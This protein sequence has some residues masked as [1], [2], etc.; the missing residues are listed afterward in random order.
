MKRNVGKIDRSLRIL[1]GFGIMLAGFYYESWLG[2]F[3]AIPLATGTLGWCPLY[4]PFGF[5]SCRVGEK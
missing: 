5:S 1:V 3:G 2:V 4:I